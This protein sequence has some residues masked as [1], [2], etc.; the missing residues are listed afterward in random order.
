MNIAIRLLIEKRKELVHHNEK[1]TEQVQ[2]LEERAKEKHDEINK[3]NA[4]MKE[5]DET[6][7]ILSP[8]GQ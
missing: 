2:I 6:I 3:N 8:P 7:S 4:E 5:I 1:L